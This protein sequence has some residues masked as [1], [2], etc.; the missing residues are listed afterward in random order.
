MVKGWYMVY[1]HPSHI[2]NPYNLAGLLLITIPQYAVYPTFRHG[3]YD[4]KKT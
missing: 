1:G 2:G 3:T 4:E